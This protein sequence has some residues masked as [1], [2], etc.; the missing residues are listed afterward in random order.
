MLTSLHG[1][2]TRL[3]FPVK[4]WIKWGYTDGKGLRKAENGIKEPIIATKHKEDI[5]KNQERKLLYIISD[6]M[7][8][9][10]GGNN[11]VNSTSDEILRDL[12]Q[13]K[14]F[15]Q[16]ALSS[17]K[18]YYSLPTTRLDNN[19]SNQI[20]RNLITKV[21]QLNYLVMDNSNINEHHLSN[22]SLHFNPH[23]VRKMASNIISFMKHL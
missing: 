13:L 15:I 22:K 4:C 10:I 8:N 6:S 12:G 1:K 14:I 17:C 23:S 7:L 11:C 20:R 5:N 18:I 16:K 3:A 9:Q 2:N 21:R 19:M